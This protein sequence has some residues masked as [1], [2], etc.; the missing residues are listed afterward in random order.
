MMDIYVPLF[1]S[2]K[3][4]NIHKTGEERSH[5]FVQGIPYVYR[6]KIATKVQQKLDMRK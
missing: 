2:V 5:Q 4:P 1:F 3:N 6:L